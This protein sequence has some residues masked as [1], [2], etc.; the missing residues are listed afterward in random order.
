M[1]IFAPLSIRFS[2]SPNPRC[3]GVP[4]GSTFFLENRSKLAFSVTIPF[5]SFLPIGKLVSRNNVFFAISIAKF[6]RAV[7]HAYGLPVNDSDVDLYLL[8]FF[9]FFSASLN[10]TNR[11]LWITH[12][13]HRH[14]TVYIPRL[15][16]CAK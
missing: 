15:W 3:S 5:E 9:Q 14:P 4:L 7:A 16:V 12:M 2:G 11:V 10:R 1:P 8:D 13:G 6:F